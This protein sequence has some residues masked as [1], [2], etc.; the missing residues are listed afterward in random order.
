M[1]SDGTVSCWGYP[2]YGQTTVPTGTFT[3]LSMGVVHT[4]GVKSDG[5]LGCWGFAALNW[6]TADPTEVTRS[7][8][9]QVGSATNWRTWL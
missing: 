5:T 8:P 3:Q 4:C 9:N 7:V 1:Q 2:G 6:R